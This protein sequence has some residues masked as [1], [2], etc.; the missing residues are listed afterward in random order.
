MSGEPLRLSHSMDKIANFTK[1]PCSLLSERKRVQQ[2]LHPTGP[3]KQNSRNRKITLAGMFVLKAN[4][5]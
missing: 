3:E 2:G 1:N 4:G 5:K